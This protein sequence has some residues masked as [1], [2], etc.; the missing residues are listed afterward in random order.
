MPTG[1][2]ECVCPWY[3]NNF[4]RPPSSPDP[5]LSPVVSAVIILCKFISNY[6]TTTTPCFAAILLLLLAKAIILLKFGFWIHFCTLEWNQMDF[7][8]LLHLGTA[9]LFWIFKFHPVFWSRFYITIFPK[10]WT[11]FVLVYMVYCHKYMWDF[12]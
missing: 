10:T 6:C 2:I 1:P 8:L 11:Q 12:I 7:I 5:S 9:L 3:C 4:F